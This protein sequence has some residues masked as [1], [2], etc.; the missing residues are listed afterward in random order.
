MK[1]KKKKAEEL[2]TKALKELKNN[3]LNIYI[4]ADFFENVICKK[5]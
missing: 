3:G 1:R 5:D 2:L 4:D